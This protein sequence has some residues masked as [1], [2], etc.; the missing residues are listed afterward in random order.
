[1]N[2]RLLEMIERYRVRIEAE[3]RG[4]DGRCLTSR[5][6]RE[7]RTAPGASS[8]RRASSRTSTRPPSGRSSPS[9][10]AVTAGSRIAT[11]PPPRRSLRSTTIASNVSPTRGASS[12]AS[13]IGDDPRLVLARAPG[14]PLHHLR[15]AS[16]AR[17]AP[18]PGSPRRRRA[19]RTPRRRSGRRAGAAERSCARTSRRAPSGSG[20]PARRRRTRGTPEPRSRPADSISSAAWRATNRAEAADEVGVGDVLRPL[21]ARAPSPSAGGARAGRD[22][23]RGRCAACRR[24]PRASARRRPSRSSARSARS[25][26]RPAAGRG[27][28]ARSRRPRCGDHL[29]GDREADAAAPHLA[30]PAEDADLAQ[31]PELLVGRAAVERLLGA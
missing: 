1:M 22:R 9:H 5:V 31:E 30:L 3:K 13:M 21:D 16:G 15:A 19:R 28:G 25:T 2:R 10:R 4:L 27:T 17:R 20:P 18:T 8:R 23:R 26:A 11:T 7:R 14:R 24:R 6:R 29:L 12:A